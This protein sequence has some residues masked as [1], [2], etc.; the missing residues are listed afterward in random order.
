MS[1][2]LIIIAGTLPYYVMTQSLCPSNLLRL[3]ITTPVAG[4]VIAIHDATA[5]EGNIGQI[6]IEPL[7]ISGAG[8]YDATIISYVSGVGI[9]PALIWTQG[10]RYSFVY[11]FP[12]PS[13]Y[14]WVTNV[15]PD[16]TPTTTN[17]TVTLTSVPPV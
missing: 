8:P 12:A 9:V 17:V 16:I 1:N 15:T 2:L 7:V 10:S 13:H 14:Y 11:D 6:L 3:D 4:T 5:G